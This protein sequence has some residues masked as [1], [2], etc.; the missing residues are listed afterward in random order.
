[1]N[2]EGSHQAPGVT[3]VQAQAMIDEAM[4]TPADRDLAVLL[5]LCWFTSGR[6]GDVLRL[7]RKCVSLDP[8]ATKTG[9]VQ[10]EFRHHKTDR[11][12]GP[13]VVS[14]HIPQKYMAVLRRHM[15][16][17]GHEAFVFHVPSAAAKRG[18]MTRLG[19]ALKAVAPD[20]CARSL[21]RGTL[22]ALGSDTNNPMAVLMAFSGHVRQATTELYCIGPA[23]QLKR[24]M[25]ESAAARLTTG[26]RAAPRRC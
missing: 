12:R 2:R 22:Q 21:R 15:A 5:I 7:R 3:S 14:T 17:L 13:Y 19:M 4:K 11:H 24:R 26:N 8:D 1:M 6:P 25:V 20:L 16:P 18:V 10:V 23:G 9:M